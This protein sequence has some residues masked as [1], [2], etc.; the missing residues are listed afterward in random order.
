MKSVLKNFLIY[1]VAFLI[2][3][4][5]FSMWSDKS[6]AKPETVDLQYMI[7]QINNSNV[8]E[9]AI[10]GDQLDITLRDGSK[11]IAQKEGADSFSDIVKNFNIDNSKLSNVK[12]AVKSES[13]FNF[14]LNSLLP[15]ILPFVLIGVFLFFMMR[16]VARSNS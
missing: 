6:A 12:V 14:W 3:A 1:F 2:I 16:G 9:I 8:S 5:L 15:F 13:S 7:M 10:A 4:A 11:K